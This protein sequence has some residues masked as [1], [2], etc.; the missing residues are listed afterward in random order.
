MSQPSASNSEYGIDSILDTPEEVP[1]YSEGSSLGLSTVTLDSVTS[2]LIPDQSNSAAG[3][4]ESIRSLWST[5][6][7]P[8]N[9]GH[10]RDEC[11]PPR[12]DVIA[13]NVVGLRR[14]QAGPNEVGPVPESTVLLA[15][16]DARIRG[17]LTAQGIVAD[18]IATGNL[19]ADN[20]TITGRTNIHMHEA[21][22]AGT[23]GATASNF[24]ILPADR[25]DVIYANPINGPVNIHLGTGTNNVFVPN[26]VIT[27]KDVTPEFGNGSSH[28]VN[29][30]VSNQL[31]ATPVRI[32]H[33]DNG[34]KA[35]SNS[36]YILNTSGGAVTFRF[37]QLP[38]PGSAPTWVIQNE[39]MGNA[40]LLGAGRVAF[41]VADN[42]TKERI[43]NLK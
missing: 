4:T 19:I 21:Y 1:L 26:Q 24:V 15:N 25:I 9:H 22:Y 10:K 13:R 30:I 20:L 32:E 31:G 14:V 8:S 42:E 33:Y 37:A 18:Q 11:H 27:I 2:V 6:D 39:F 3:K 7:F 12:E 34:L 35:S 38:V 5:S 28:N 16:G 17:D 41:R 36:R 29:I 23:S 43:I 40:R